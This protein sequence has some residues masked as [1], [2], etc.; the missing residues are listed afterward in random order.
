MTVGDV[1]AT[2]WIIGSTG[3]TLWTAIVGTSVL[4]KERAQQAAMAAEQDTK[5]VVG[6]GAG[7]FV[8][9]GLFAVILIPQPNGL[10]KLIGWVLLASLLLLAIL[11]SSGLATLTGERLQRM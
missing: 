3:V 10:L 2:V 7:I 6:I 4:F 1:N 8:V 11:G 9:A 5:K